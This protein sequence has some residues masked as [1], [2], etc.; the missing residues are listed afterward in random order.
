MTA[1]VAL[2]APQP[3]APAVRPQIQERQQEEKQNLR[4]IKLAV[5]RGRRQRHSALSLRSA[6]N[7]CSSST[8]SSP[9]KGR[10]PL[11][12]HSRCPGSQLLATSS[13]HALRGFAWKNCSSLPAPRHRHGGPGP[14]G[15]SRPRAG[16]HGPRRR[17][18]LLLVFRA[19]ATAK[20][21]E[22]GG[23]R[24]Q[25]DVGSRPGRSVQPCVLVTHPVEPQCPHPCN[26]KF[27]CACLR[28][29][30]WGGTQNVQPSV[31]RLP[32]P[33][34]VTAEPAWNPVWK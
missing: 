2:T 6:A 20:V 22:E 27:N 3:Q 30:L 4:R 32:P 19:P 7:T 17:E 26:G 24:S 31:P 21:Q 23:A 1:P 28:G 33:I 18:F 34:H 13:L 29:S 9:Q 10:V 25:A 12:G 11:S 14:R 16:S 5:C 15:L 8:P